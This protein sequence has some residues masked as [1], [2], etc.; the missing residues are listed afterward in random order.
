MLATPLRTL[1]ERYAAPVPRYTSY[2]TAPQ[3]SS[4]IGPREAAAWISSLPA[5]GALSLYVHIPFCRV[6]CWYCGCSTTVANSPEPIAAYLAS[7][8]AEIANVAA[9]VPPSHRVT[10]VHWGG[11]SP[12]TLS[13]SETHALAAHIRSLFNIEKT[14][15]FA[16]EIDPRFMEAERVAALREVGVNRVSIGVQ[17]FDPDVQAAINRHQPY[18]MTRDVVTRLR[19]AGIPSINVD[20]VYGLPGQTQAS[21]ARTLD[22]VL[23]L[24]PDRVAV[25]GYAHIPEKM[26]HQRLIDTNALAGP[27]GRLGQANRIARKLLAA[28]YVRVG[29]D[30]FAKPTDPLVCDRVNRNFQGYTTDTADALIGFGSSAISR[31]PQGYAQNAARVPDYHQRIATHRLA[32]A[33]GVAFTD[34]DRIRGHVIE[35]LM[36]DLEFSETELRARFGS[37]AAAPLI[38]DARLLLDTDSD[39]LLEPTADGFR[40]SER[41]RPFVRS[42]CACFDAYLGQSPARHAVGV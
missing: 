38:D 10:H 42:I 25:F 3:F 17:D 32:T 31:F 18:E 22:Q 19:D 13:P 8:H 15:E 29:L 24:D 34:D 16:I 39:G 7:L 33:R 20:L 37:D 14:A 23:T 11:G 26:R 35:R 4:A 41:G 21:A 1:A 2:P 5:D 9:L 12:N 36:C 30:H 6:L 40:V 28:G 27:A